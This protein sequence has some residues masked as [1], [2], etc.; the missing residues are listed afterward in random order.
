MYYYSSKKMTLIF[1]GMFK[2]LCVCVCVRECVRA[3]V[4]SESAVFMLQHISQ[5]GGFLTRFKHLASRWR[6]CTRGL[7][8]TCL[9]CWFHTRR[10]TDTVCVF[11]KLDGVVQEG[12]CSF[13]QRSP[14]SGPR[15]LLS[16]N[17]ALWE[18]GERLLINAVLWS[19]V[20]T[21]CCVVV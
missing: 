19:P 3:Y 15:K 6:L 17:S 5:S 11:L 14:S 10:E 18:E 13:P 20:R 12:S 8:K 9:N 16:G 4:W 1:F 21:L 7:K 2:Q